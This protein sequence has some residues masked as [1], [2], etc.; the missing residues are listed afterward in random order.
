MLQQKHCYFDR[1]LGIFC[2]RTMAF[3]CDRRRNKHGGWVSGTFGREIERP[4]Y[5]VVKVFPSIISIIKHIVK[6]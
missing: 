5:I 1:S 4:D 3:M 2:R 6:T